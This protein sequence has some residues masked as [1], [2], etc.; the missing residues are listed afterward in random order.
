[1]KDDEKHVKWVDCDCGHAGHAVRFTFWDEKDEHWPSHL[2]LDVPLRRNRPWYKRLVN[3]FKYIFGF[4]P[5]Y[6]NDIVWDKHITTEVVEFM[7]EY[8]DAEEAR[9]AAW[10]AECNERKKNEYE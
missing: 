1:M 8:L 9:Q 4:E 2:Y 5:E 7:Q 6:Y 3:G 10:V